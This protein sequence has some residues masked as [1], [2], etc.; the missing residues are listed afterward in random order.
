MPIRVPDL[1]APRLPHL[2]L[3]RL[4][5]GDTTPDLVLQV[6]PA[7]EDLTVLGLPDPTAQIDE[8]FATLRAQFGA[9]IDI[10]RVVAGTLPAGFATLSFGEQ[11]NAI[12]D[13]ARREVIGIY[14]TPG[15]A[16]AE[17][18]RR[19]TLAEVDL[20][21]PLLMLQAAGG[22]PIAVQTRFDRVARLAEVTYQETD[23][24]ANLSLQPCSCGAISVDDITLEHVRVSV[25]GGGGSGH[26]GPA[27]VGSGVPID[28]VTTTLRC[29]LPD[30]AGDVRFRALLDET[31][32]KTTT[33][34]PRF[35][36]TTQA[37]F[38]IDRVRSDDLGD[39]GERLVEGGFGQKVL[40]ILLR[41]VLH[42]VRT[43]E[44][45]IDRVIARQAPE[46]VGLYGFFE[47]FL[48]SEVL[49]PRPAAPPGG[50]RPPPGKLVF[51]LL[52]AV[53]VRDE[54]VDFSTRLIERPRVP[55]A[56][57]AVLGFS[58]HAPKVHAQAAIRD[59]RAPTFTWSSPVAG[60]TVEVA[61]DGR[62]AEFTFPPEAER[63]LV[64]VVEDVADGVR[65]TVDVRPVV[66]LVDVHTGVTTF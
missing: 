19:A 48:A 63:H 43:N 34:P 44:G 55:T 33:V 7:V 32:V 28:A 24:R 5:T 15:N 61:E 13:G 16:L 54:G 41:P 49:L 18:A 31:V 59:F 46:A 45:R 53:H 64:L 1:A 29:S 23:R 9:S 51:E 8:V 25:G 30:V 57:V 62:T 3:P 17:P 52:E 39:L 58:P 40:A 20:G 26:A 11:L 6:S 10:V 2:G 4:P 60:V 36:V 47:T 27:D 56:A 35:H 14:A 66:G 42:V 65:S 21:T 38:I 22:V 50:V 37:R 12:A